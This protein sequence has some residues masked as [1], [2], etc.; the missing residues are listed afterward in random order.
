MVAKLHHR[1]RAVLHYITAWGRAA[2]LKKMPMNRSR[3]NPT[4][5]RRGRAGGLRSVG[6]R[7]P[8]GAWWLPQPP[9]GM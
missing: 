9:W 5:P 1:A 3:K 4:I 8:G 7:G 6:R 2:L